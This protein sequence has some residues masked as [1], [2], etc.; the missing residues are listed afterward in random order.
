MSTSARAPLI[1]LSLFS[2]FCFTLYLSLPVCHSTFLISLTSFFSLSFF[3]FV[4]YF[5]VNIHGSFNLNTII[6]I[7]YWTIFFKTNS[8]DDTI[9]IVVIVVVCIPLQVDWFHFELRKCNNWCEVGG[10][11]LIKQTEN[12]FRFH[13]KRSDSC[14]F[15][16]YCF[17]FSLFIL[18]DSS[19]IYVYV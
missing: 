8:D 18:N 5:P 10:S 1:A 14:W 2:S 7:I 16:F 11:N 12:W 19:L 6:I 15:L 13:N 17:T 4:Y 3:C 9:V